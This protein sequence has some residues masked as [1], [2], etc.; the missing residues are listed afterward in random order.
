MKYIYYI[1]LFLLLLTMIACRGGKSQQGVVANLEEQ[2]KAQPAAV[3][4]PALAPSTM[5]SEQKTLYMNEHYWD[6]VVL[7]NGTKGYRQQ[8]KQKHQHKHN[9]E[10]NP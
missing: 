4:I 3:F 8:I 2:P 10:G 6:K 7:P 9:P 1:G 5:S